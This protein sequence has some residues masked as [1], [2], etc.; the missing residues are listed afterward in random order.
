MANNFT[1]T[2][3]EFGGLHLPQDNAPLLSEKESPN[4]KNFRITE[5]GHLKLREGFS[6]LQTL[7]G[8]VRALWHGTLF[9]KRLYLALVGTTL[10]ASEDAFV[11]LREVGKIEG[12][13]RVSCL[14]FRENLYFLTGDGILV[15]DGTALQAITPYRPLIR[16]STPP[17]GGG[18]PFEDQNLLTRK[19]RQAFC[20]N[21]EHY[22][23]T[24]A[25]QNLESVDYVTLNG[26]NLTFEKH[27]TYDLRFGLVELC[28]LPNSDAP[29]ATDS[30]E[31]GYT[32]GKNTR[33]GVERCRF[34]VTY[35]GENDTRAFLYGD[36][37][38]P[39]VRYYSGIA[40]GMPC[41]EYFPAS[42]FSMVGDGEKITSIVRHYGRQIIFTEHA[43]YYS[44]PETQ[45]DE[46]GLQYTSFPVFTLSAVRGNCVEGL[47]VLL[48][49]K[50]LSVME[51][52]L[53]CWN[54]TTVRDERNAQAFS[55]PIERALKGERLRD[56]RLF[57]R[58]GEKELYLVLPRGIYVY[59]YRKD[60]FYYYEGY[61]PT[62][63]IEDDAC[64]TFFGTADG[65][66]CVL[67]GFL[68]DG[69]PIEAHRESGALYFGDAA[70][71]KN[72]H[73]VVLGLDADS[74]ADCAL[75]FSTDCATDK[76]RPPK[77]V[78]APLFS[79]YETSFPDLTFATARGAHSRKLR[80][81][82]KRFAALSLTLSHP[83]VPNDLCITHLVLRGKINDQHT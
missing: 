51:S 12:E 60:L 8:P 7:E 55:A 76:L 33:S 6:T 18:V 23:F 63:M 27:Y 10:Y 50:P 25:E 43:A 66:I 57:L 13:N 67:E 83:A 54:N 46:S 31:I 62:E 35:G 73:D 37:Y 30:L 77:S 68:D 3:T 24:L 26:L 4:M 36:P 39:A 56:A 45:T 28:I 9:K 44:Y 11:T 34:G 71:T 42:N 48:D 59:N 58:E 29:T 22:S 14:E 52:G 69:K 20:G 40:N 21:G 65:K 5:N 38:N 53:F 72:L 47:S 74:D 80:V 41:M 81:N 15:F 2:L 64:R 19:V 32:L 75:S 78:S 1:L 17:E 79:F 61:A 82:A 16:V 70:H 49:N